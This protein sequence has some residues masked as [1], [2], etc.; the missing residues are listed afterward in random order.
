MLELRI[1]QLEEFSRWELE[2]EV[3]IVEKYQFV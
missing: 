3:L 1:L 2:K